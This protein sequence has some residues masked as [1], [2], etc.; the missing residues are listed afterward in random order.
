MADPRLT[1]A[2]LPHVLRQLECALP[3]MFASAISP[4]APGISGTCTAL[5]FRNE[6]FFVTAAHVVERNDW[7]TSVYVPLGFSASETRVRI[8]RGWKPRAAAPH[9]PEDLAAMRPATPPAF[10][11]GESSAHVVPPIANMD[12]VSQG[13]RFVVA[14]YP[15]NAVDRNYVDYAAR[16]LK[17]GKQVA[18]GT[19]DGSSPMAGLHTLKL[20]TAET[21]GPNGFSGGPAFRML[22]DPITSAWT[23][24]FAG[25]VTNGG[26][27]CVHFIDSKYVLASLCAAPPEQ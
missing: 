24:A 4:D 19:Y 18:F 25:I 21:G 9:V 6:F 26:P 14:G 1:A 13:A 16:V 8:G 15:L 7:Q 11:D 3:V 5:R 20:S 17:F 23:L 2:D 10:V 12:R 27:E 22:H